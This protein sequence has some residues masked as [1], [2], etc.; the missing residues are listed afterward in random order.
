[1][2]DSKISTNAVDRKLETLFSQLREADRLT[3]PDFPDSGLAP[4]AGPASIAP[5]TDT[6]CEVASNKR[7]FDPPAPLRATGALAAA[8]LVALLIQPTPQSADA[9][10]LEIMEANTLLTDDMLLASPVI[11]PEQSSFDDWY[12]EPGGTEEELYW[13]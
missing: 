6:A 2:S 10:Y 5:I 8:V 13:N 1:M 7:P 4:I 9:L 3:A 12:A 11:A